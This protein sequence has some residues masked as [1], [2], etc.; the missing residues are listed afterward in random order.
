MVAM[1]VL[2]AFTLLILWRG[3]RTL[4]QITHFNHHLKQISPRSNQLL[5]SFNREMNRYSVRRGFKIEP[6]IAGKFSWIGKK[7][8]FTPVIPFE[9]GRTYQVEIQSA[10]DVKGIDMPVYQSQFHTKTRQFIFLNA[11]RQLRLW[12]SDATET[13]TAPGLLVLDYIPVNDGEQIFFSAVDKNEF[14]QNSLAHEYHWTAFQQLYVFNLSNHSL[15]KLSEPGFF[16]FRFSVSLNGQTRLL[17]RTSLQENTGGWWVQRYPNTQW[18]FLSDLDNTS[19]AITPNGQFMLG[20]KQL[21]YYLLSTDP[22]SEKSAQFLGQFSHTY[23]FNSNATKILFTLPSP[24]DGFK[25][26]NYVVLLDHQGRRNTYLENQGL[27]ANLR[28]S[29]TKEVL[30]FTMTFDQDD[31]E[32]SVPYHLHAFDLETSALEQLTDDPKWSDESFSVSPDGRQLIFERFDASDGENYGPDLRED[33]VGHRMT[34][35]M[36]PD[37]WIYDT[38]KK[39]LISL[40]IQGRKPKW[41]P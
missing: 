14:K 13:L 41:I 8:A 2:M 38:E 33:I 31:Y 30:Y 7:M 9:Y 6:E 5:F 15:S 23:G 4:P 39:S 25:I 24:Q 27:L 26:Y 28:F 35:E 20:K 36:M 10:K 1:G 37:L 16:N 19:Y 17:Y 40:G 22:D 12:K 21:A 34:L 32:L 3:D 11:Q 18:Q 29:P